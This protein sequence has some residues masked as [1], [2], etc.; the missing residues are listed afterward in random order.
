MPF[1]TPQY[2]QWQPDI[3]RWNGNRYAILL[4]LQ[5]Q[6]FGRTLLG[7]PEAVFA[8]GRWKYEFPGAPGVVS[9]LRRP[10]LSANPGTA[11][12]KLVSNGALSH[13]L[14]HR[15]LHVTRKIQNYA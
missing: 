2:N 9:A 7:A 11:H 6:A 13:L 1:A 15:V 3:F 5:P 4:P 14:K 12:P 10:I 8:P